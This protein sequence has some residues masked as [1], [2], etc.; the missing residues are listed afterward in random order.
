[1]EG[2]FQILEKH[3]KMWVKVKVRKIRNTIKGSRLAMIYSCASTC[4]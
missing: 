4:G 1:M 2:H 3:V